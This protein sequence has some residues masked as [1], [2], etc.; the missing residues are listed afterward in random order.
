MVLPYSIKPSIER[1]TNLVDSDVRRSYGGST[2]SL[3]AVL[4]EM[5]V[6]DG[7]VS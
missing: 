3:L 6:L 7:Y 2:A 4:L 1:W 5:N